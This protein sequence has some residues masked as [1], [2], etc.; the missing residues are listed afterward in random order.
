EG[1]GAE[2]VAELAKAGIEPGGLGMDEPDGPGGGGPGETGQ[3]ETGPGAVRQVRRA[4]LRYEGTDTALPVPLGALPEMVAAFE[5]AYRQYFSFLMR[6][7]AIIAEAVSVEVAATSA[8]VAAP[9]PPDAPLARRAPGRA[10]G[11]GRP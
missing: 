4:H 8:P 2:E 11:P 7:K 10:A 5:R 1:V 3:G 9:A 6:G